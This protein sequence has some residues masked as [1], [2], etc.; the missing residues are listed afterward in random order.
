MRYRCAEW[1]RGVGADPIGTVDAL[2]GFL[3]VPWRLPWPAEI[4]DAPALRDGIAVA[5]AAGFRVHAIVPAASAEGCRE[6]VFRYARRKV[7]NGPEWFGGYQLSE[8]GGVGAL[9]QAQF[10][11]LLDGAAIGHGRAEGSSASSAFICTHGG[12]DAC[13]GASGTRLFEAAR[14]AGYAT[15]VWRTSHTGGHRFAPTALVFPEGTAWAHLTPELLAG[16]L[17]RS[18][19]VEECV[20]RFRGCAGLDGPQVQ[21][22]DREGFARHGWTWFDGRRLAEVVSRDEHRVAVRLVYELADG[23]SGC[24]RAE[25]DAHRMLPVPTCGRPIELA[26]RTEPE[27]AVRSLSHQ[28]YPNC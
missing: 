23:V 28:A 24:F 16:I 21:V 2:S 18:A 25:V 4:S 1:A 13:C 27:Y 5:E 17:D 19:P 6:A 8:H 11:G 15:R 12:R 3:F 9:V 14:S 10:D 22:V 7:P 20:P 26:T